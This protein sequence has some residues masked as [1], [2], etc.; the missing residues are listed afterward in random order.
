M[1]LP[2]E[3]EEMR[4]FQEKALSNTRLA[5]EL[6]LPEVIAV[7]P[8]KQF[9]E[10]LYNRWAH[11]LTSNHLG[12]LMVEASASKAVDLGSNPLSIHLK[13]FSPYFGSQR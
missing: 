9:F 8:S 2:G 13:W 3:K 10:L 5:V 7:L 12:D 4:E 1:V 11:T 6:C